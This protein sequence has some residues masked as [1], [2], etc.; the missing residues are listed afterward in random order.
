M[1]TITPRTDRERR[2]SVRLGFLG[3][4]AALTLTLTLGLGTQRAHAQPSPQLVGGFPSLSLSYDD[5]QGPGS[6]TITPLGPDEATGGTAITVTIAQ[7][8][9]VYS[10]GG[11]VRQV[12]ARGYVIAT[13][14]SGE[15]GDS[16]FLSGT[17]A[18]GDDGVS[19]RGRGRWWAVENRVVS[20][21]WHMAD[22]PVIQPP[23]RPQ[24]STSVRLDPTSGSRVS[25]G[26]TLVALPQG[27][28]RFE[29]QLAGL[30]PGR[31]Y[32]VQL[33]AGTPSQPGASFTQVATVT[34]DA[35]GRA[36]T[37][38]LVRF[39][40]TEAI[41]LLDIA[42]GNH[43]ITVVGPSQTVAVGSIPALQPLG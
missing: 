15:Y 18:R 38:G 40:G 25:G 16:Y 2:H 26:V 36:S 31:S 13:S 9:G 24:L 7:S 33:H 27:E 8:G 10:G 5:A 4:L 21:E 12:D 20:G 23:S 41:P 6:A 39:R 37:S 22:W 35:A 30:L 1:Q 11:F 17:L 14:L 34:A 32:G 28:T 43:V 19:W 29:L 42:D 3:L